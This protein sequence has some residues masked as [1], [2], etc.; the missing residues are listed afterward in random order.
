MA[1]LVK[2]LDHPVITAG[3]LQVSAEFCSRVLGIERVEFDG[4][5]HGM[6]FGNSEVQY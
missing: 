1:I 3:D 6:Y 2:S 4:G 5:R